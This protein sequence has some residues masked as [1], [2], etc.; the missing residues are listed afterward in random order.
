MTDRRKRRR[1]PTVN[2]PA[3]MI[4]QDVADW[5]AGR[6]PGAELDLS[7]LTKARGRNPR[8]NGDVVLRI[9][10]AMSA[11][12]LLV[13]GDVFSSSTVA[14]VVI[15]NGLDI[16]WDRDD[17]R[18]DEHGMSRLIGDI[19]GGHSWKLKRLSKKKFLAPKTWPVLDD[20]C[21]VLEE[22]VY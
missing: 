19:L 8:K 3:G 12:G 13:P 5:H 11:K 6:K 16:L 21:G 9:V 2:P 10:R 14:K 15:H 7:C 20:I 1:P 22:A 4:A 17:G 18:K